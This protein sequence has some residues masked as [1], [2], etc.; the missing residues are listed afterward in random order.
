MNL[1]NQ[2]LVVALEYNDRLKACEEQLRLLRDSVNSALDQLEGCQAT[3]RS[4]VGVANRDLADL[5]L[6]KIAEAKA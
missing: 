1:E 5:L 2:L 3:E 6:A 4:Y